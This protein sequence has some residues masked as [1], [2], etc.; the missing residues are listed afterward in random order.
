MIWIV[1]IIVFFIIGI[2]AK[3]RYNYNHGIHRG[4]GGH[5]ILEM[6]DEEDNTFW[7]CNKCGKVIETITIV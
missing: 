5:W 1:S 4:C 6:T 2:I 3:D 7:T